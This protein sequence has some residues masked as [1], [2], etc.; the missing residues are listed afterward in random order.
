MLTPIAIPPA[1]RA[2]QFHANSA[3]IMGI[4]QRLWL[5]GDTV[6]CRLQPDGQTN[7][8]TLNFPQAATAL[9]LSLAPG[10]RLHARGYLRDFE[11]RE[12][13]AEVLGREWPALI[14]PGDEAISARHTVINL[15]VESVEAVPAVAIA[16]N[17]ATIGGVVARVWRLPRQADLFASLAVY[18]AHTDIVQPNGDRPKRQAHYTR[19]VFPNGVTADGL[20][21]CLVE[22]QTVLVT[23]PLRGD[24]YSERLAEFL[25]RAKRSDRLDEALERRRLGRSILRVV[26]ERL[27]AFNARPARTREV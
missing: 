8:I 6:L 14:Q 9:N 13:L 23:G 16:V 1:R 24:T 3:E 5:E 17:T 25:K 2:E 21:V 12:T 20:D 19:I 15:I 18:D 10:L 26:G 7:L 4:V 11:V 27:I 22:K